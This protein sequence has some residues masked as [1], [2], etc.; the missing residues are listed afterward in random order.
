MVF[1]MASL[2]RL[3]GDD[4]YGVCI[5]SGELDKQIGVDDTYGNCIISGHLDNQV[6]QRLA[7]A[8]F[9]GAIIFEGPSIEE[10]SSDF[11]GIDHNKPA[12]VLTPS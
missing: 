3:R 11:G 12:A 8:E 1:F 9:E 6:C 5:I 10:A 4:T 7:A 2:R